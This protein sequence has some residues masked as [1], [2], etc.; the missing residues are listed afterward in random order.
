MSKSILKHKLLAVCLGAAISQGALAANVTQPT[1]LGDSSI[2]VI[3]GDDTFARDWMVSIGWNLYDHWCGGSLIN[4][5][6]VMTAAHCVD[7][8]KTPSQFTLQIGARDIS[9]SNDGVTVGASEIH[10]HP[11][12]NSN[13][14]IN[15]IALIKLATPVS[16][17]TVG[18]STGST[19][20]L[21]TYFTFSIAVPASVFC[22]RRRVGPWVN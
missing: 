16:N 21:D 5:Q 20:V 18:M 22:L 14:I 7:G 6:W 8:G 12:W 10:I 1:Q 17:N 9:D 11:S 19:G 2:Q 15:D 13:A 4:S 3:G